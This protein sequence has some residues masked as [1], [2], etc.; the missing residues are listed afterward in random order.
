M[1]LA[2]TRE[3]LDDKRQHYPGN[4]RR[5]NLF[6]VDGWMFS[7]GI[8]RSLTRALSAQAQYGYLA[9]ASTRSAIPFNVSA[10]SVRFSLIWHPGVERFR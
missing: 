4:C 7:A 6:H 2:S 8:G 1:A 10:S 3:P 9:D 5:G